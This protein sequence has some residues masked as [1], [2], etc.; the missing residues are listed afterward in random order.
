M[1]ASASNQSRCTECASGYPG[2]HGEDCP[3]FTGTH[4]PFLPPMEPCD[5]CAFEFY[6]KATKERQPFDAE[7]H[8]PKRTSMFCKVIGLPCTRCGDDSPK[9][10]W[11][12]AFP[13]HFVY[14]DHSTAKHFLWAP[15]EARQRLHAARAAAPKK[16]RTKLSLVA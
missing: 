15:N 13:E 6:A 3:H 11:E 8:T 1:I 5:R 16:R 2:E 4:R 12:P 10:T 9:G 14:G 7:D